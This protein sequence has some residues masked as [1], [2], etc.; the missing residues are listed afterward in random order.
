MQRAYAGKNR[1]VYFPPGTYLVSDTITATPKRYFI[2]GA[3]PGR[4]VIRLKD[5]CPGFDDPSRPK[6]VLQNWDQPIGTGS[7]GQGFR[8]SYGDLAVEIGVGNRGAIGILY[9]SDEHHCY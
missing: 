8:N 1:A 3:G 5:H 9:F 4:T 6:A 2:Q 7:N